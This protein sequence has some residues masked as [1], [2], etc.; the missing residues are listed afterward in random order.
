MEY[1]CS[2]IN[3]ERVDTISN[4]EDND[5]DNDDDDGSCTG[6]KKGNYYFC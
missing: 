3:I 4:D 5:D 2:K 6:E 1:A